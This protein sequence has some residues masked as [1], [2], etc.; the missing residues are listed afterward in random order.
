MMLLGG[1]PVGERFIWWNLV[2]STK[3]RLEQGKADWRD[4][5]ARGWAGTPFTLPPGDAEEFIPLPGDAYS[6]PT[7]PAR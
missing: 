6:G 4:S 7:E 3:E 1:A 5:A 2:A